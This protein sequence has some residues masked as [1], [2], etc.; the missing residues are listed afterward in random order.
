M[1]TTQVTSRDGL[2]LVTAPSEILEKPCEPITK[3]TDEIKQLARRMIKAMYEWNGIGLAAPQVGENIQ[4]CVVDRARTTG[5]IG[6]PIIM[7]NPEILHKKKPVP[8]EEGCL[9]I[10]KEGYKTERFTQ[11]TVRYTQMDGRKITVAAKAIFA[12]V[13]QHEV[14]HLNGITVAERG[15]KLLFNEDESVEISGDD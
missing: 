10:P 8:F 9:S 4:L 7:I 6:P 11:I 3:I 15:E 13:I 1:E 14:D 2:T 12:I 5:E